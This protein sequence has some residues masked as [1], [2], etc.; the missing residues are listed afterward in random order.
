MV[1]NLDFSKFFSVVEMSLD[2]KNVLKASAAV[3]ASLRCCVIPS[4]I[5]LPH[6]Q[7]QLPLTSTQDVVSFFTLPKSF[8][9]AVCSETFNKQ[10]SGSPHCCRVPGACGFEEKTR[11]KCLV[12]SQATPKCLQGGF[13]GG[14]ACV[15]FCHRLQKLSASSWCPSVPAW[16]GLSLR[17][18][19]NLQFPH[20]VGLPGALREAKLNVCTEGTPDVV[21]GGQR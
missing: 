19:R 8:P 12:Q 2:K 18:T 11:R 15:N 21:S 4:L 13:A 10:G 7:G 3:W 6:P 1:T 17:N 16:P 9:Q 5:P 20:S 14:V